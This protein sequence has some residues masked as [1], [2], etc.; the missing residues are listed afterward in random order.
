MSLL[1]GFVCGLEHVLQFQGG[2]LVGF[3]TAD[4]VQAFLLIPTVWDVLIFGEFANAGELVAFHL[5]AM[6]AAYI[7]AIGLL[8]SSIS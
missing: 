7:I 8:A 3:A 2:G 4:L 5:S 6:C 1:A